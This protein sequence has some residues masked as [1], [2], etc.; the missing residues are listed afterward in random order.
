MLKH[1]NAQ[2]AKL[3]N[4]LKVFIFVY[5]L[6]IFSAFF[7]AKRFFDIDRNDI[8]DEGFMMKRLSESLLSS[9][10]FIIKTLGTAS[11]IS[12]NDFS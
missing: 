5:F 6:K 7:E 11:T 3:Y 12:I 9:R 1:L 10:L 4:H 8:C 2:R